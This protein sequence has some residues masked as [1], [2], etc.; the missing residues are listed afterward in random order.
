MW[1]ALLAIVGGCAARS[2][3]RLEKRDDAGEQDVKKHQRR[4]P[5]PFAHQGPGHPQDQD[6]DAQVNGDIHMSAPLLRF[7]RRFI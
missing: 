6:D 2:D 5:K 3:A 1:T 4:A 7:N